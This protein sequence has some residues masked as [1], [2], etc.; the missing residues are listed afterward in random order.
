MSYHSRLNSLSL[1]RTRTIQTFFSRENL[2][3]TRRNPV[4]FTRFR[5]NGVNHEE[6]DVFR[7]LVPERHK[8]PGN[9]PRLK[10]DNPTVSCFRSG[11]CVLVKG[12]IPGGQCVWQR[13]PQRPPRG[14]GCLGRS[15]RGLK[16]SHPAPR[17][18][19]A[20][21]IYLACRRCFR[22]WT[23]WLWLMPLAPEADWAWATE[24]FPKRSSW[25][26]NFS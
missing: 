14:M 24:S 18:N 19:S 1:P 12:G 25:A 23:I 15:S 26:L 10:H 8:M 6:H 2:A 4:F 20:G 16:P 5:Q 22:T 17:A 11:V 7:R 21:C 3:S 13:I 9:V